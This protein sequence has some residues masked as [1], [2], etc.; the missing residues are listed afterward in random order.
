MALNFFSQAL[1]NSNRR[2][3]SRARFATLDSESD[4]VVDFVLW[5][6]IH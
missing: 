4:E 5:A 3:R 1:I 2:Q 6:N